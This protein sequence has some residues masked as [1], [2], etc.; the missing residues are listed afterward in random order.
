M[1][2]HML[3][4]YSQNS[5]CEN[6]F[7]TSVRTEVVA[8]F[9]MDTGMREI[10]LEETDNRFAFLAAETWFLQLRILVSA[11]ENTSFLY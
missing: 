3:L 10:A 7:T 5:D 9:V 6:F 1:Y 8:I 11:I 4:P 2:I